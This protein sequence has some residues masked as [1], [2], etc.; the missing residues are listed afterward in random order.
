[1][2]RRLDRIKLR[3]SRWRRTQELI[4]LQLDGVASASIPIIELHPRPRALRAAMSPPCRRFAAA[5]RLLR[6]TC[7]ISNEQKA[8][9]ATHNGSAQLQTPCP[10][11]A[12]SFL[13]SERRLNFWHPTVRCNAIRRVWG[14]QARDLPNV[15]HKTSSF[16]LPSSFN[17]HLAMWSNFHP[18]EETLA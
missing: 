15:E 17:S 11:V 12:G 7:W 16:L 3:K 4:S 5:A 2:H 18:E 6:A 14:G 9:H 13:P 10:H 8:K 1:M